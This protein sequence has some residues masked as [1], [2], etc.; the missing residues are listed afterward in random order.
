M[1]R[2]RDRL[3]HLPARPCG[4]VGGGGGVTGWLMILF[5][6]LWLGELWMRRYWQA[7]A[8]RL[9]AAGVTLAHIAAEN[10]ADAFRSRCLLA[11]MQAERADEGEDWKRSA[12][13]STTYWYC[14]CRRA[15]TRRGAWGDGATT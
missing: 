9:M 6:V 13:L 15:S 3:D 12:P 8:K 2:P 7:E 1:R 4:A 14:R 11:A 10:F 5:A